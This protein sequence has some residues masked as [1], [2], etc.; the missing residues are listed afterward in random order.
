[1][2]ATTDGTPCEFEPLCF[3]G[4][5]KKSPFWFRHQVDA[6]M[7]QCVQRECNNSY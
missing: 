7:G 1:M 5:K 3:F 4:E 6:F 2:S